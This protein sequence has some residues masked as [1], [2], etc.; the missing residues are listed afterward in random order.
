[1]HG[2]G[3]VDTILLP[4]VAQR[5]VAVCDYFP[6]VVGTDLA[7]AFA[8]FVT[9]WVTASTAGYTF[10]FTMLFIHAV[11]ASSAFVGL[12]NACVVHGVVIRIADAAEGAKPLPLVVGAAV[13]IILPL[14]VLMFQ[15][16]LSGDA[17][18]LYFY[19]GL[20]LLCIVLVVPPLCGIV[21]TAMSS[22][23]GG[24]GGGGDRHGDMPMSAVTP[25]SG[26]VRN[27]STVRRTHQ[28]QGS[29][30]N[31]SMHS[32]HNSQNV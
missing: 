8:A 18:D 24:G 32:Q 5:T 12:S 21:Q 10:A 1:M 25:G 14:L 11:L 9:A 31:R 26:A 15:T 28:M 29:D 27:D 17:G 20:S 19:V 4:L 23:S 6:V 30:D 7:G 22:R 2:D 13:T 3:A 16:L